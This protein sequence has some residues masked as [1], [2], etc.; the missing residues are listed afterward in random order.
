MLS[1]IIC[2]QSSV[3]RSWFRLIIIC[4]VNSKRVFKSPLNVIGHKH[5][6]KKYEIFLVAWQKCWAEITQPFCCFNRSFQW[7]N[8]K[9]INQI[10]WAVSNYFAKL[11]NQRK[12]HS[13]YVK[14][15][16]ASTLKCSKAT[17]EEVV[18]RWLRSTFLPMCWGLVFTFCP[19]R[20]PRTESI[21][22]KSLRFH[23]DWTRSL[24]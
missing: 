23:Q 1:E 16:C 22:Q 18:T 2:Q 17:A 5:M 13:E 9:S 8:E 10:S 15:K 20:N 21:L 24:C 3:I 6:L 11:G 4:L 12:F 14:A 19:Y 7:Q